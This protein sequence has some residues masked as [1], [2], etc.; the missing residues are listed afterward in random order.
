[1]TALATQA[2]RL[3]SLDLRSAPPPH[4]HPVLSR[5]TRGTSGHGAPGGGESDDVGFG[6]VVGALF[7]V[8]CFG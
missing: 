3:V 4:A 7:M 8:F 5:T 2:V 6:L 1:M